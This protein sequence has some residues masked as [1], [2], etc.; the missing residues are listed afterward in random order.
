MQEKIDFFFTPYNNKQCISKSMKFADGTD[1]FDL[2]IQLKQ[3]SNDPNISLEERDDVIDAIH[4]V[5]SGKSPMHVNWKRLYSVMFNEKDRKP[6]MS[7]IQLCKKIQKV[8][9][10]NFSLDR[11]TKQRRQRHA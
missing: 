9:K 2:L 8:E 7:M 11:K 6:Y 1:D 4:E 3:L 10:G 5:A